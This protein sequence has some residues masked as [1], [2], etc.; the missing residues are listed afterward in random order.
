MLLQQNVEV[1]ARWR[2]DVRAI[3]VDE[4]QDTNERQRQLIDLLNGN[5]GKLFIVG[6]AKQ[7]IYRFRGA[8]VTVFRA[9]RNRIGEH[10]AAYRLETSYRAHREMVQGL[11]GLM[12]PVLGDEEDPQRQWVEPFSRLLHNREEPLPGTHAP[13]IEMH[14]TVGS[15]SGGALDRAADALVARIA[16]LQEAGLEYGDFAILCRASSAFPYYEDALDRAQIPFLTFS[17]RGFYDRPEIRDLLNALR[18]VAD[19]TDDLALAGLLRSP[20]MAVSDAGLYRLCVE[21]DR[22]PEPL[23]LW[24][25]LQQS[26]HEFG[27]RDSSRAGQAIEMIGGL[28][29]QVGR[30]L[31]ADVL[32]AFLDMTD[33]RALMLG[34]GKAR[35]ARNVSKL[36]ADAHASGIVGVGEFLEYV[37]GLRTS[38]AREGEARATAEGAVQIMTVHAAKGLEFPVVVLGNAT[39][40]GRGPGG[41]LLPPE[42]GVL[43]PLQDGEGN[44][45]ALYRLGKAIEQDREDA[46]SDR[47]LYVA[48]TR[49]REMLLFSGN[50]SVKK[51]GSFGNLGGW[52]GEIA[53]A[54]AVD[55]VCIDYDE[56]GARVLQRG[57]QVDGI[58]VSCTI[59]E[60]GVTWVTGAPRPGRSPGLPLDLPPPLLEPVDP[61]RAEA[62]A[63][64]EELERDPPHRVW[65]VVP[66]V[67]RPRAPAW[68]IG[69]LVHAAIAARRFPDASYERWAEARARGHGVTDARQLA[70]AVRESRELLLRFRQHPLADEL[71]DAERRLHEVPYSVVIDRR[72]ERGII[73][74]LYLRA[75]VWTII[76]FKTDDVRDEARLRQLIQEEGYA[77]Q[78]GRYAAAVEQL[79]GQRPQVLLCMLNYAGGIRVERL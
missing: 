41:V 73:D 38:G 6:D 37:E 53:K 4:F 12:R 57:L 45:P 67:A 13:F 79:V 19:P 15:K 25:V 69:S 39:F 52:L 50:V 71:E 10:G 59:Y 75:G 61:R 42:L 11:N 44:L 55:T 3:L 40:G 62:D 66:A 27:G 47:L 24:D 56:E 60:P 7:S 77:V 34:A 29:D 49:A 64:T 46:E 26:W 17:G 72:V 8:D 22:L 16:S 48:A 58:P 65:R 63:R 1:R 21:R 51:D 9:E 5:G 68:V 54:V 2:R 31:I 43:L 30:S 78:A 14:L 28:H 32:K 74:A 23:P 33:Y 70:D 20:A 35:E 18:A 36:L 76:E